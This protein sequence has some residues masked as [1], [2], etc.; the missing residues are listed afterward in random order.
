MK[1]LI[2]ED[3]KP[4][5]QKLVR[6]IK[7][8]DKSIEI[9][10]I[11]ESVEGA[12]NWLLSNSHPELIF[13]D[14]QLEDGICFEIFE[15]C[16]I[17]TPVIFTTAYDEYALKAFKVN[18]VDYLLKPIVLD[19]LKNAI[20]K[21]RMTHQKIDLIKI[22]SIIN[23]LKTKTKERFL[24]KIGDHYRSVPTSNIN[25]F[26][27]KERCN[28]I[29]IKSGKNY[30]ID[31]SLDKIEQ[32]VDSKMFF[33]V[34]RNFIINFSAIHDIIVYSSNRLKIIPI[35]WTEKEE[36]LVSRERVSDFKNWMDR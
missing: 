4:A 19:N 35:N 36:I 18:S 21:F 10:D 31:Y 7:E 9:V 20:D 13:M 3:E 16:V 23:Q 12:T 33:R 26:Y 2:I 8:I 11:I 15:N 32:L 17:N 29:N 6:I 28:F 30:A 1:V 34:N 25:C 24:I 5:W 14:I 22:E 27:I